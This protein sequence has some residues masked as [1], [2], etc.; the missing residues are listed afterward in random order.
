VTVG[1]T[2][3]IRSKAIEHTYDGTTETINQ[4]RTDLVEWL[5]EQGL[6]GVSADAQ[7]VVSE[8]T[9]NAVEASPDEPY[10][11]AAWIDAGTLC[12]TVTNRSNAELPPPGDWSPETVLA[13]QGRG[14]LI[15]KALSAAVHIDQT[16][17]E[18]VVSAHLHIDRD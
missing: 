14:L 10:S 13:P 18:T 4:A 15:V 12:I 16:D 11:V 8:L 9:S 5:L 3:G 2:E 6:S 1:A 17:H 7:L